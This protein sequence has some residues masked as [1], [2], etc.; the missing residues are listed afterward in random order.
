[1]SNAFPQFC[2]RSL[3]KNAGFVNKIV[4]FVNKAAW[5]P[6]LYGPFG[7]IAPAF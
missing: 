5:F 2:K 3:Q 6:A 7:T 1:M 4:G